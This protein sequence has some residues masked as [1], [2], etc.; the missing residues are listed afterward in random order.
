M[1]VVP[2]RLSIFKKNPSVNYMI[3]HNSKLDLCKVET[4]SMVGQDFKIIIEQAR[5]RRSG[6]LRL[7]ICR[8]EI[9]FLA[10]IYCAVHLTSTGCPKNSLSCIMYT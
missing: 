9:D 7:E 4:S 5:Y 6:N 10:D 2:K 8:R 3:I 1:V